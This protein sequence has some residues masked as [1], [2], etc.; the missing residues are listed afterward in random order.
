M[1]QTTTTS[2]ISNT[3]NTGA[4]GSRARLGAA[5]IALGSM[6]FAACSADEIASPGTDTAPV[7]SELTTPASETVAPDRTGSTEPSATTPPATTAPV[8]TP[9][10]VTPPPATNPPN[11]PATNPPTP[12]PADT[13]PPSTEDPTPVF[14]SFSAS[15]PAACTEPGVTFQVD[16]TV[17]LEWDI[18]GATSVYMA[19]DDV[20]GLYEGDLP[21]VGSIQ[22]ENPCSGNTFFVVAENAA[23]RTVME[24]TR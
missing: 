9:P 7:E 16:R 1:K 11:P 22:I 12:N 14:N 4:T 13:D 6:F 23:G 3:G 17:T 19:I 8:T 18:S 20:N 15:N 2:D 10:V 5:V 21:A 24:A